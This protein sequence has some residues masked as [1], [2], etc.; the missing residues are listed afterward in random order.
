[1][2]IAICAYDCE[3][4][5]S[6][7]ATWFQ[8]VP[9][10]LA[11]RG[12][13]VSAHIFWWEKKDAGTL[14]NF[15]RKHSICT[16]LHHFTT[17]QQNVRSLLKA[18]STN[19]P[20]VLIS[21]NV[22]PALLATKYLKKAGIP[23]VGIIRSDDP[24]Y[25]GVIERFAAGRDDDRVNSFVAVSEFLEKTVFERSKGKC[26]TIH[27]PSGAPIATKITSFRKD[28]FQVVYVG[29]LVEEQKRIIETTECMIRICQ[30]IPGT[31]GVIVGDGPERESVEQLVAKSNLPISVVGRKSDEQLQQILLNSQALL[32]LSDYEGTPTAVM[33]AM[34]AGVV[35]VCLK[36]RSGIPELVQHEKTGLHVI[37]RTDSPVAAIRRLVTE[38]ET[39]RRMSIAARNHIIASY[40]THS[41]VDRWESHLTQIQMNQPQKDIAIPRRIRLPPIHPAYSH[42]DIRDPAP[43]TKCGNNFLWYLRRSRYLFGKL[44]ATLLSKK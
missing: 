42:Q 17:S 3:N 29:R 33:E 31:K 2:K 21:D 10:E 39:W 13:Q 30:N 9:F 18:L 43:F 23:N 8:R 19:L 35:P 38:T 34:S 16:H 25:H 32:L 5:V 41:C 12:H 22:I 11:S 44:R 40:S 4:A 20:D 36:I 15:A 28:P 24:F 1:M 26:P 6:G 27:I 7:P 37:D 14:M